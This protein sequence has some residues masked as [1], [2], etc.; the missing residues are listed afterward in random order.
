MPVQIL[1][2][3]A[4]LSNEAMAHLIEATVDDDVAVPSLFTLRF[5]EADDLKQPFRWVDDESLFAIGNAVEIHFSASRH[6]MR[7]YDYQRVWMTKMID[8]E[9]TALEPDFAADERPSLAVRGYD[10][11]H[12][13]QRGRKT[14]TFVKRKD[15]DI[16]AQIA[17]EAGLAVQATDSRVVIEYL[18]QDNRTDFE[19]LQERATQIGWE[20]VIEDKTLF[21]RPARN[22][23]SEALSLTLYEDLL[24]FSPRLSTAGQIGKITVRG[25]DPKKK[26]AIEGSADGANTSM[27]GRRSGAQL[28][29]AFGTAALI[30]VGRAV[31]SQGEADQIARGLFT[32]M[33]LELITGEGACEGRTDLRAGKVIGL[34]GLGKRFSGSYYVSRA[35]HSHSA[36]AY[37]TRFQV[38]RTAL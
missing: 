28:S 25:W 9:I 32:R 34:R 8:G 29:A 4:P 35:I 27:G 31:A 19:L 38:R 26:Q 22:S 14:R 6:Q 20:V 1:V 7:L 36:D 12:R 10:R 11:R 23:A 21:F 37:E 18:L 2:N 16:A 17:A 5:A 30:E 24:E 15:S 13:L 3:G 33:A